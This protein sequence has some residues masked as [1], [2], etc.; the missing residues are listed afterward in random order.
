MAAIFKSFSML[1]SRNFVSDIKTLIPACFTYSAKFFNPLM[2]SGN[3][4]VTHT[5]VFGTFLLP[6]GIKKLIGS[7]HVGGRR[8][9]LI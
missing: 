7:P 2:P 9:A 4:K 6:P 8:L 5:S 1:S 3:K